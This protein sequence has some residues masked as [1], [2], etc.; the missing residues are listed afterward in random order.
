M[1]AAF[2][3]NSGGDLW[4]RGRTNGEMPLSLGGVIGIG[5]II[6]FYVVYINKSDSNNEE[7][8]G[9]VKTGKVSLLFGLA[10]AFAASIFFPWYNVRPLN[11]FF[12]IQFAWRFFIM[13]A[14][15]LSLPAGIGFYLLFRK[16]GLQDR[17]A[18][19]AVMCVTIAGSAYY[20]D[21]I[22]QTGTYIYGTAQFTESWE[23]GDYK[24]KGSDRRY[25][26][27]YKNIITAS[28]DAVGINAEEYGN[29]RYVISYK[30]AGGAK[31]AWIEIPVYNFP[32]YE[33][34]LDGRPEQLSMMN[35]TNNFIRVTLPEGSSNGIIRVSY[36]GLKI[37]IVGNIVSVI[38]LVFFLVRVFK[39]RLPLIGP[40]KKQ[41]RAEK[42]E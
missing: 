22:M 1:F 25:T 31:N 41:Q 11:V 24:Y 16:F 34:Y 28:S 39:G 40:V 37:F 17:L 38:T 15:L 6:F 2:V 19:F 8:K 27:E 20:L 35:G 3:T 42:N 13:A 18:V 30:N 12:H 32:G 29:G 14:P 7:T 36:R 23:N 9:L 21:S 33:A 10:A 5:L 4:N 26:L